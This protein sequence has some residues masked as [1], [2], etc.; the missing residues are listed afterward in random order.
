[1]MAVELAL[2]LREADLLAEAGKHVATL[3]EVRPDAAETAFLAARVAEA[4]GRTAD[5]VQGYEAVI[6]KHPEYRAAYRRLFALLDRQGD[7]GKLRDL[8]SRWRKQGRAGGRLPPGGRRPA[9]PG[10][11]G[12][13]RLPGG[14]RARGREAAGRAQA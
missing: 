13:R 12:R 14:A 7:R 6:Q 2:D 3:R 11:A 5:A 1:M 10:E 9:R 8:A 4:E